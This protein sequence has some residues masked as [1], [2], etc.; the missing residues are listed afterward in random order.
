MADKI[1]VDT[2]PLY[3][4]LDKKDH[5]HFW[6]N[7]QFSELEPPFLTCESVLSETIFLLQRENIDVNA[8]FEIVNRGDLITKSV[9][10]N[11]KQQK[12]IQNIIAKYQNI[13]ASFADACLV[14]MA[15]QT[16]D[17]TILTVDSDFTIY[18]NTEGEPLSLII[19]E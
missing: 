5:H 8:I 3:A 16:A 17:S 1:I 10:N 19:P 14:Q 4:F 15:E 6:V 11:E 9:F 12:R 18:R 13:G 7:K 2:G